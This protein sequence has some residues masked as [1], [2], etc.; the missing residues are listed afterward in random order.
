MVS[1][2]DKIKSQITAQSVHSGFR[3]AMK[4]KSGKTYTEFIFLLMCKASVWFSCI[5]LHAHL[6]KTIYLQGHLK[7]KDSEP[8]SQKNFYSTDLICKLLLPKELEDILCE[9]KR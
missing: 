7:R 4:I 9:R 1:Y 8:F 5:M 6:E 2:L 3:A